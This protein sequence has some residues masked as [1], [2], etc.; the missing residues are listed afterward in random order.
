LDNIIKEIKSINPELFCLQEANDDVIN[1]HI[2]KH[3]E[4]EYKLIYH[5]NEGSP[6][7]NVIG[8]KKERFEV[9]TEIKVLISDDRLKYNQNNNNKNENSDSD[10]NEDENIF[11]NRIQ[12]D[13]N[14]GIINVSL[15]DKLVKGKTLNLFCVHF[16]WR[17]I[18]EYQKA[19]IMA[20]I[21]DIIL[22]KR[23]P[24][25]IMAGDF[26]SIPN[27]IAVRMVYYED[28]DAEMTNNEEYKGNFTFFKRESNLIKET[29][30]KMEKKR[31]F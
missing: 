27:S 23:I 25:V 20:L 28:W 26:N 10:N 21:F 17:P 31:K 4:N 9:I 30:E 3:F 22:K 18:Y 29:I 5:N 2:I 11:N 8:I 7:K 13:G 16:P 12:V 6:L 24:N 19:R 15:R 14:R 1:S